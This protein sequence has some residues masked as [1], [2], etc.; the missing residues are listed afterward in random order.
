MAD[1]RNEGGGAERRGRRG[2]ENKKK[3]MENL[4]LFCFVFLLFFLA[5]TA[6]LFCQHERKKEA[7]VDPKLYAPPS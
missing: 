5:Y 1:E 2:Q 6:L 3:N 7:V 4:F